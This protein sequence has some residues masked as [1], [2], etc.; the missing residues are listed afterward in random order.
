MSND[1]N[2]LATQ[3]VFISYYF[4]DKNNQIQSTN[5]GW[6]PGIQRSRSQ[7]YS[8]KNFYAVRALDNSTDACERMAI[9]IALL[10]L[11]YPQA[12]DLPSSDMQA[13][14]EVN[15]PQKRAYELTQELFLV[16]KKIADSCRFRRSKIPDLTSELSDTISK[17]Q[18]LY[19]VGG[20]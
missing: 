5:G 9:S 19:G 17:L 7:C 6:G 13:H 18:N 11:K 15:G 10:V 16:S 3:K 2:K 8:P 4:N 1:F 12:C 14:H 20:A